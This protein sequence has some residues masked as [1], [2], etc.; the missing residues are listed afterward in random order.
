MPSFHNI[1]VLTLSFLLMFLTYMNMYGGNLLVISPSC[2]TSMI[3][4]SFNT[5]RKQTK[6]QNQ[7]NFLAVQGC[8]KVFDQQADN[9]QQ[10]VLELT[11]KAQ[12]LKGSGIQ[13]HMEILE[14]QKWHFQGFQEVFSTADAMLFHKNTCTHKT[15][16]NT[17]DPQHC[18][19]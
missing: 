17:I 2:S 8:Q 10:A 5:F 13:G 14:S 6:K 7:E 3:P 1:L 4:G 19:V 15:R 9:E 18:T 16:N 11:P 12:V